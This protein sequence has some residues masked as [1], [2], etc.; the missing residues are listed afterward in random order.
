M[1][2]AASSATASAFEPSALG[3]ER[4]P[5]KSHFRL[6]PIRGGGRRST[7]ILLA[8]AWIAAVASGFSVVREWRVDRSRSA[9][10]RQSLLMTEADERWHRA[11]IVPPGP[12]APARTLV[13]DALYNSRIASAL[14]LGPQR[15][16]LLARA[17]RDIEVARLRRPHWGDAWMLSAF[18]YSLQTPAMGEE[19]RLAIIR[20]YL[21]APLLHEGGLWRTTRALAY[22]RSFPRAT[23]E[24]IVSEAASLLKYSEN[25]HR[26]ALFEAVR[27]SPAYSRIFRRWS[28]LR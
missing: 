5:R 16:A 26:S 6:A 13:A 18:I 3:R 9:L 21:D 11:G 27:E 20:S 23:Q 14:P 1:T 4:Q 25:E 10:E 24:A 8:L 12:S 2:I 22:W 7:E 15:D 28:Q 19:E 17:R